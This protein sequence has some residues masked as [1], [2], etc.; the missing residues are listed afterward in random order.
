MTSMETLYTE[1]KECLR[2]LG[3]AFSDMDQVKLIYKD[4]G[5]IRFESEF[6]AIEIDLNRLEPT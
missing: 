6:R 5:I 4:G 2:Y 3:I 1:M